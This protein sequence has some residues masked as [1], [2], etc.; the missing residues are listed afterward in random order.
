M[1]MKI[2][3]IIGADILGRRSPFVNIDNENQFHNL[4]SRVFIDMFTPL[5]C[6]PLSNVYAVL[7]A[8]SAIGIEVAL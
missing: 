8:A 5:K 2:V 6:V 4:S 3:F 7:E 1:K